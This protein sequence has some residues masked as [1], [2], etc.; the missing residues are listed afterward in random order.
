MDNYDPLSSPNN[1]YI[2]NDHDEN[3]HSSQMITPNQNFIFQNESGQDE[4]NKQQH[5]L[6]SSSQ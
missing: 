1:P 3:D 6:Y 5:L 4:D 2:I